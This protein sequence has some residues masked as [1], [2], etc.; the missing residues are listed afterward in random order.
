MPLDGSDVRLLRLFMTI[1]ESGG[2]AAAQ[3]ELNLSL[4]TI[5]A[6]VTA[7]E[8]RLG[9]RLC[10]RGR[11]GFALTEEG[12][13]VYEE[14][15]RLTG[16]IEQ[17]E[18]RVR[19]LKGSLSGQL[20]V[21]IVDNTIT[22]PAAPLDR[23]FAA[24]A[25]AAPEVMLTVTSRP[26]NELLQGVVTGQ[27][28]VAIASFPKIALGL[29][30]V[31]LYEERQCFYCGSG[32]PLFDWPESAVDI[33]AIRRFPIVGR[34]YWG[35]RDLKI[36]AVGG[37]KA[38]VNDMESEARLILSGA[39]LGYLPAHYARPFVDAGRLK[40]LRPDLFDYAA[41]FQLA[42]APEK[43]REPIA[44]LFVDTVRAVFNGGGPP[45]KA[46]RPQ[47]APAG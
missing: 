28:Q 3:G 37:P 13:H 30:Y 19:N 40:A 38:V 23:V 24:F 11:S 17:F 21:G 35:Q 26:P 41:P 43:L 22:D 32:H 34:T 45:A 5:S 1:V 39:Y 12:R 42:H 4:S 6:H 25:A 47:P 36:F 31:D 46:R 44:K 14:A 16:S 2:F 7:L 8:T 9:V 20:A 15:R 33:D 18:N 29:S 27:L 10:R